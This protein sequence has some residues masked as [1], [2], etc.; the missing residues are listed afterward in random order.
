MMD[1]ELFKQRLEQLAQLKPAPKNRQPRNPDQLDV[2]D[3]FRNG[4]TEII[5]P[6]NNSTWALEIKEIKPI[7]KPCE[8]CGRECQDRKTTKT[9]YTYPQ[10]H[11]RSYCGGC[12]RTYNPE[13]KEFDLKPN[14]AGVF[15]LRYLKQADK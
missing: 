3:V 7:I 14:Q 12:Q 1:K 15:F 4:Q 13:T 11:W 2:C 5:D 6:K 9:L 8:D 10:R